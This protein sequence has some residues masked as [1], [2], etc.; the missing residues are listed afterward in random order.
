MAIAADCKSAPF[1]V[2]GFESLSSHSPS[3]KLLTGVTDAQRL[4]ILQVFR[5]G[6]LGLFEMNKSWIYGGV[7]ECRHP[8]F[9]ILCPQGREGSSPSIPTDTTLWADVLVGHNT[10]I[11]IVLRD[12]KEL[13]WCNLS[14]SVWNQLIQTLMR[15]WRN[16]RR[17]TLRGWWE[18]SRVSSSLTCRTKHSGIAQLARA[19]DS[20]SAGWK[21]EPSY[22][23]K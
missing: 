3:T 11:V 1:G 18:Q 17:A 13:Q 5:Q 4:R 15:Q 9:R 2:R 6:F 10:V 12:L 7:V 14:R 20:E 22:R 23:Y 19:A 21:F 8:R 16:G